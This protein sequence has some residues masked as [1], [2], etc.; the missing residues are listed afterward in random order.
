MDEINV[1]RKAIQ[2]EE[3]A[4]IDLMHMHKE[5]LLR[6]ALAFLK[7][8]HAALEALQETTYRAFKKIHT[9]K[10]PAYAKTWLIRI[11]INYCQ[12]QL[13][14]GKRFVLSE[15]NL[16]LPVL[17]NLAQIE[18]QEALSTLSPTEQ[19]LIYMKYFQD[20][21]IK[22]IAAI[23]KIPEGTVKSRLHK[24][25]RTLRRYLEDKGEIDH[26]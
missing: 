20:V 19:Q 14:R 8:E 26:V 5:A 25:L 22:D 3:E 2:G 9:L 4:F 17:D 16:D 7:N 18:L 10:E 11:M 6:T 15:K 1:A 21:K 12:D 13:K 24:T 23:E